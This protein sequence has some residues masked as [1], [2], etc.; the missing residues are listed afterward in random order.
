MKMRKLKI[1]EALAF[2]GDRGVYHTALLDIQPEYRDMIIELLKICCQLMKKTTSDPR[3]LAALQK[4]FV[5]I[6]TK[7]EI[8]LPVY[9]NT[10]T[11]H[12]L[13]HIA[14]AISLMGSFWAF[15]ML[16]AERVHVTI[17]RLARYF[18]LLVNFVVLVVCMYTAYLLVLFNSIIV[19]L[20]K[21]N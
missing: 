7:L 8:A 4:R 20:L 12:F 14:D 6:L 1:A 3:E 10:S 15:S 2:C 13:L 19:L 9:W 18:L 17:K 5:I 11:R 21:F 16:G